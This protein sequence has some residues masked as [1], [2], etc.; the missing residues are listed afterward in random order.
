MMAQFAK[1]PHIGPVLPDLGY[2]D[3]QRAALRQT[4]E[5]SD[6]EVVVVA[7]PMDLSALVT[8]ENKVVRVRYDYEDAGEPTLGQQLEAFL[9][10]SATD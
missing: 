4:I 9:A 1:Y 5:D 3:A 2:S 7:A 6:A 8:T 10:R